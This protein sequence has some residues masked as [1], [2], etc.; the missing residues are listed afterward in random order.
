[1]IKF[2]LYALK[3]TLEEHVFSKMCEEKLFSDSEFYKLMIGGIQY[4]GS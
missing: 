1:M 4:Q 2:Q 3:Q